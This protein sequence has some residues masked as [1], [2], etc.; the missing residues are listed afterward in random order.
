[1]PRSD[2]TIHEYT[3][4]SSAC[5][6]GVGAKNSDYF[7]AGGTALNTPFNFRVV[8][9][10]FPV[11]DGKRTGFNG[12]YS[13]LI[14][15]TEEGAQPVWSDTRN[16]NPFPLNGSGHDEN[17]FTER[18]LLPEGNAKARAGDVGRE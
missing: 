6:N 3:Y 17:S 2:P 1:M 13:G 12:D 10:V 4:T 15:I 8:S 16:L 14:I 11:P 7:L 5:Q 18:V 9:P